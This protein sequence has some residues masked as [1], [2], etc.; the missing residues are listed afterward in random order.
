M[1]AENGEDR[2]TM[3]QESGSIDVERVAKV[4]TKERNCLHTELSVRCCCGLTE[5]AFEE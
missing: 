2:E 5:L 1:L 3:Y 4:A